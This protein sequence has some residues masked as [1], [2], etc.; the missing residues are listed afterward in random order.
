MR[1]VYTAASGITGLSSVRTLMY[2]TAPA[3]KVVEILATS[4]TNS[5]NETNEQ[6]LC[7]WQRIA[8]IGSPV[9]TLL[10]PSKHEAGDQAAGSTV[11]CN[12]TASEPNYTVNTAIGAEGFNSLGGWFYRPTP[13]ERPTIG[14]QT[15]M[16]LRILNAPTAFDAVVSCTFREIG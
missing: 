14:G 16:G 6:L 12:I 2:I 10:T 8:T 1:G 13:E 15:T 9:T 5:S 3:D 7:Q 4:V 11:G